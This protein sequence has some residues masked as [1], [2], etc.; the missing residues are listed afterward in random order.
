MSVIDWCK[1]LAFFR[2]RRWNQRDPQHHVQMPPLMSHVH[3]LLLHLLDLHAHLLHVTIMQSSQPLQSKQ[4]TRAQTLLKDDFLFFPHPPTSISS[5]CPF[6]Q[7]ALVWA[8]L[9]RE[10]K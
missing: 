9:A 6:Q 1:E 8:V 5:L 2:L 10:Q 3:T 7:S 4:K